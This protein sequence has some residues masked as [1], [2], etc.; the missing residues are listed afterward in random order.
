MYAKCIHGQGWNQCD[1]NNYI[2]LRS[3]C[4]RLLCNLFII[5]YCS[6]NGAGN[7]IG[8]KWK[9]DGDLHDHHQGTDGYQVGN[10]HVYGR[11][12]K[13]D[14]DLVCDEVGTACPIRFLPSSMLISDIGN[15]EGKLFIRDLGVVSVY[16]IK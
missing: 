15:A 16:A 10:D 11:W 1:R 5:Q 13:Q 8:R 2:E 12:S 4:G 14:G 3:R 6:R 7:G 9:D